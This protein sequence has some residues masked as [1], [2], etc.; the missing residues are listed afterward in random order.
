[1]IAALYV[2]TFFI[3]H[4]GAAWL[5]P[6]TTFANGHSDTVVAVAIVGLYMCI[7]VLVVI[8]R[9]SFLRFVTLFKRQGVAPHS[10]ELGA[11]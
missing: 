10:I 7:A 11:I 1:M 6:L 4:E 9:E 3:R 5:A 2:F 8:G